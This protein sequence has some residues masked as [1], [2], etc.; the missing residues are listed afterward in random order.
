MDRRRLVLIALVLLGVTAVGDFYVNGFGV[1]E[2]F[3]TGFTLSIEGQTHQIT[4]E[5]E[6]QHDAAGIEQLVLKGEAAEVSVVAED[7]DTIQMRASIKVY[8]END[9]DA[10]QYV[11]VARLEAPVEG[12]AIK[13][14]IT[15]AFPAGVTGTDVSWNIVV[16]RELAIDVDYNWGAVT[17]AGANAPVTVSLMG[18]VDLQHINA[19]VHLDHKAGAA[20][21]RNV[22]GDVTIEAGLGQVELADITGNLDVTSSAGGVIAKNV[23]GNVVFKGSMTGVE[24]DGV[25]GTFRASQEYG[26]V[27]ARNI[28]GEIAIDV[29]MGAAMIRP[30]SA[31]PIT[32]VVSQG[33]LT[34]SIPQELVDEYSFELTTHSGELIKP[35]QI[36]AREHAEDGHVVDATVRQGAL[37]VEVVN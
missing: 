22:T 25:G 9:A 1:F 24:V 12:S 11:N 13:P 21:V 26:A 15:G 2:Q 29:R 20:N 34:L 31:A 30:L 16:P 7:V 14:T 8:G 23:S 4:F 36:T 10:H 5:L 19:P 17:I 28:V 3:G 35:E 27:S 33:D 18:T 37:R 6:S 32:A